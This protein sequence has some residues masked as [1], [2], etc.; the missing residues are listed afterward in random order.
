[1]SIKYATG[2]LICAYYRC[3]RHDVDPITPGCRRC[4]TARGNSELFL[5]AWA[6]NADACATREVNRSPLRQANPKQARRHAAKRRKKQ[7]TYSAPLQGIGQ[8][9]PAPSNLIL[10]SEELYRIS[11][12]S[13]FA[14]LKVCQ[15]CSAKGPVT[16]G[17]Q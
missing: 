10:R 4:Q 9:Q 1:M 16:K 13:E 8:T 17:S 3:V 5:G 14:A 2:I 6:P 7:A 11:V 12:G 15:K